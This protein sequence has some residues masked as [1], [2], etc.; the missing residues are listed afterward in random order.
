MRMRGCAN[1]SGGAAR[2]EQ[3]SAPA[4]TMG[5][6]L[7]LDC[8]ER[9]VHQHQNRDA[10][11]QEPHARAHG[12]RSRRVGAPTPGTRGSYVR[13]ATRRHAKRCTGH[14][15]SIQ[16]RKQITCFI[17]EG[18]VLRRLPC[19]PPGSH[20][21]FRSARPDMERVKEADGSTETDPRDVLEVGDD[22]QEDVSMDDIR[23][24]LDNRLSVLKRRDKADRWK[25]RSSINDARSSSME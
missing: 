12:T 7:T 3:V 18:L 25:R 20:P 19:T 5:M 14:K 11:G 22:G 15:K 6:E 23:S 8:A 16:I 13:K 9:C 21:S 1:W 2:A 24:H 17:I 4:S 10:H